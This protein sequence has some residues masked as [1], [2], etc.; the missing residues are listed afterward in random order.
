MNKNDIIDIIYTGIHENHNY[1]KGYQS[2]LRKKISDAEQEF[3]EPLE[4]FELLEIGLKSI[5]D[6]FTKRY[7]QELERYYIY[8]DKD[9]N[10]SEDQKFNYPQPDIQNHGRPFFLLSR[11]YNE[12]SQIY[13][14][15]IE[16]FKHA[17]KIV[18]LKPNTLTEKLIEIE[19]K[20]IFF[21]GALQICKELLEDLD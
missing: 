17:F 7:L 16:D 11:K 20:D 4:F 14:K 3:V 10:L 12:P 13:M 1:V 5:E 8:L 15:D 19:F 2:Y 21:D 9:E 18:R 6:G